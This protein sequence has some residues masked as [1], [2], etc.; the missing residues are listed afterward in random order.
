MQELAAKAE[1]ASA[2]PSRSGSVPVCRL[3]ARGAVSVLEQ[4]RKDASPVAAALHTPPRT[5]PP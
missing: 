4:P 2:L 5:G 1:G 3:H